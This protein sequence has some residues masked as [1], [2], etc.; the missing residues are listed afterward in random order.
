MPLPA[1]LL[2]TPSFKQIWD[3]TYLYKKTRFTNM[4]R[5][6]LPSK[7]KVTNRLVYKKN[8][9]GKF[10]TPDEKL[11]IVSWSAPQYGEYLRQKSKKA[12]RQLTIKHTYNLVLVLQK[13]ILGEYS[14]ESK[15]M[16][17][18]GSNKKWDSTPPQSKIKTIYHST[19]EKLKKKHT[20]KKTGK[21]DKVEYNKAIELIKKKGKYISV[22]D[23]NSQERG[24]MA[25]FYF[26]IQP[27]CHAYS[28]L[29]GPVTQ[30]KFHADAGSY[31]FFDKHTLGVILYLIKRGIIKNKT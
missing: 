30:D 25:D 22:G 7:I 31:P 17:R 13:D 24:I 26:R 3:Y 9:E 28:C 29:Y 12:S 1:I 5:D 10:S 4:D 11:E 15:V 2:Q 14:F 27:L 8:K 21:L 19:R 23:Y 20:N 16:W 6:I 18:V